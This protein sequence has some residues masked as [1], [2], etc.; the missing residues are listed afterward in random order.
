M[1]HDFNERLHFSLKASDEPFWNAIY[2]KAFPTLIDSKIVNDLRLQKLGIDRVLYFTNGK[3]IFIDEKKREG[4]WQDILLEYISIDYNNTPGWIEKNLAIDYL[5]YA[6]MPIYRVYL[7]PWDILQR[8]WL[9]YKDNWLDKYPHIE[10]KNKSY[11]TWS[12]AIPIKTLQA[13]IDLAMIIQL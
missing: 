5:A 1:I 12:V 13:A 8:A 10:S 11:S 9:H 2:K 3:K 4:V 7:Y 6:F